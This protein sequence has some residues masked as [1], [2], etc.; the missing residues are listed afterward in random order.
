MIDD[1]TGV[2]RPDPAGLIAFQLARSG[3]MIYNRNVYI[4][5]PLRNYDEFSWSEQSPSGLGCGMAMPCTL[6]GVNPERVTSSATS[7][8]ARLKWSSWVIGAS[9]QHINF[10]L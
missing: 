1:A 6:T 7:I 3:A 4:G 8:V 2:I 10:P 9:R 5:G